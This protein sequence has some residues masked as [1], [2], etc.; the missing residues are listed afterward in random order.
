MTSRNT[1]SSCNMHAPDTGKR[2]Q[3]QD[4]LRYGDAVVSHRKSFFDSV[5]DFHTAYSAILELL[6]RDSIGAAQPDDE[7]HYEESVVLEA[8]RASNPLLDYAGH[9]HLVELYMKDPNARI[10]YDSER[11]L[12]GHLSGGLAIPPDTLY[13][14]TTARIAV[15]VMERGLQSPT[16]P[17]LPLSTTIE[18]A[19]RK[20]TWFVRNSNDDM[21][22]VSI[23]AAQAYNDHVAF[24]Y[25]AKS[26]EFLVERLS[27]RYISGSQNMGRVLDDGSLQS[28]GED[29]Q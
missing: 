3:G 12:L 27:P 2:F 28:S 1:T 18:E 23:D 29:D 10:S 17:F 25:S 16:K 20:C 19:C 24:S 26:C 14:A 8:L 22:V 7:G 6:S 11:C 5:E 4:G 21:V 15:R 13:Y 9:D